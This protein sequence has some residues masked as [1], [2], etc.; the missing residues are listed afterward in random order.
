MVGAATEGADMAEATAAVDFMAEEV[1]M[2]AVDFMAVDFMGAAS[3]VARCAA[4][5][6]GADST[7]PEVCIAVVRLW[8]AGRCRVSGV[9]RAAR[10]Q[11]DTSLA[12]VA[13]FVGEDNLADPAQPSVA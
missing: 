12:S 9:R 1:F 5:L 7:A 11:H 8:V 2:A 6:G 4:D 13:A 3:M 10:F